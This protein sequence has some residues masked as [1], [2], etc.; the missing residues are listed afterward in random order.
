MVWAEATESMEW[1]LDWGGGGYIEGV[2]GYWMLGFT[3]LTCW[4]I[5]P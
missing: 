5:R 4:S 3:P 1:S 2:F